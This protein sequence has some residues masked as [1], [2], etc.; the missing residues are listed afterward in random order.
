M[1]AMVDAFWRAAAYCLHPRVILWSLLPLL[2]A[3]GAVFGLGWL[4]WELAVSTVRATIEQWSLV[5]SLMQWLDSVGGQALHTLLAPLI[6][7]VFAL[8]LI[9]MGSLLLVATLMTPAL[10]NLVAARRFPLLERRRGAGWWQALFWSL[11]CTLAALLALV[12]SLPLWLVPPLVLLLPP[13][14]WG[15]LTCK[16]F[17]FD[18]LA[19]HA[20]RE[21]RRRILH[22]QRWPLLAMGVVCGYLGAAPSLLWAVSAAT[23]IFA[24][25]LVLLSVWLYTLVFAFAACWFAHYLLAELARLRAVEAAPLPPAP[26]R[27]E[28]LTAAPPLPADGPP[29]IHPPPALPAP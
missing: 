1:K 8:P 22:D 29:P 27:V 2:V 21:E 12:L 19:A 20:S 23:L 6:V 10:V 13:L 11:A 5:A 4:Y 14:I 25:V 7:V 26:E 18:A 15:W 24:P 9:V 17:G 16:V 28:W 3:G